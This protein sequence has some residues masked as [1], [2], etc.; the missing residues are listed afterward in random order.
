MFV[1]CVITIELVYISCLGI[2]FSELWLSSLL[3]YFSSHF[4]HFPHIFSFE[5]TSPLYVTLFTSSLILIKA[6]QT[7]PPSR[8]PHR[9][10]RAPVWP[11]VRGRARRSR[12]SPRQTGVLRR[13]RPTSVWQ[14]EVQ[15]ITGKLVCSLRAAT[16]SPG[17]GHNCDKHIR[18]LHRR[19]KEGS[20]RSMVAFCG[21]EAWESI[22]GGVCLALLACWWPRLYVRRTARPGPDLDPTQYTKT[23]KLTMFFSRVSV[24]VRVAHLS[25]PGPPP[26]FL[27]PPPPQIA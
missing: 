3:C 10:I 5:H 23:Q 26:S 17:M 18:R 1:V 2:R 14:L 24:C 4:L 6:R 25:C 22:R 21:T 19:A 11:R 15:P 20:S 12:L 7:L 13:G 8:R 9:Q 27:L 16:R